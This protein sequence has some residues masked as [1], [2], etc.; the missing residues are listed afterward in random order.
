MLDQQGVGKNLCYSGFVDYIVQLHFV[1]SL[2][3]AE[4][5]QDP[6][7]KNIDTTAEA[8]FQMEPTHQTPLSRHLERQL[9]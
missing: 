5:L 7:Q 4:D 1:C 3:S 6:P 8:S 2:L 9:L